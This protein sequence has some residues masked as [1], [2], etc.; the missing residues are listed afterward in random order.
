MLIVSKKEKKVSKKILG[1]Q[2]SLYICTPERPMPNADAQMAKLVDALVSGASAARLAGSSPV[3]GTKSDERQSLIVARF[4][5]C[6]VEALVGSY[7][8]WL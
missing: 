4:F 8:N 1:Y 5:I 2:K 6:L 3:L 7:K